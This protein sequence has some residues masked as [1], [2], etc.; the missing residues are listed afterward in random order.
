MLQVDN[1]VSE[2]LHI[3][4][5]LINALY[6]FSSLAKGLP[7]THR[8]RT[9]AA[10]RISSKAPTTAFKGDPTTG[11]DPA[12]GAVMVSARMPYSRI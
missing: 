12:I 7:A 6:Y 10:F 11:I 4:L 9:S 5:I 3:F 2:A 1:L 8:Q